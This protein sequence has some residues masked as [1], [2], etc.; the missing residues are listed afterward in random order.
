MKLKNSA[1]NLISKLFRGGDK[2]PNR[3]RLPGKPSKTR[4]ALDRAPK[5]TLPKGFKSKEPR[6]VG[7][8]PNPKLIKKI[9]RKLSGISTKKIVPLSLLLLILV[10]SGL[11]LKSLGVFTIDEVEITYDGSPD[12]KFTDVK[13]YEVRGRMYGLNYFSVNLDKI[14]SE[15][16]ATKP[17]IDYVIAEKIF[18]RKVEIKIFESDPRLTLNVNDSVC[19]VV[20][21]S[22]L[23][24]N[25]IKF[26]HKNAEDSDQA[27]DNDNNGTQTGH[28][29]EVEDYLRIDQEQEISVEESEST[30]DEQVSF[31]E[32][33]DDS[34]RIEL[35]QDDPIGQESELEQV[36]DENALLDE[37]SAMSAEAESLI[38]S[39]VAGFYP[40]EFSNF[41]SC[42]DVADFYGTEYV[43]LINSKL[44]YEIGQQS[45]NYFDTQI[46][47]ILETFEKYNITITDFSVAN[48]IC[49][50]EDDH[51]SIFLIALN[52]D[53]ELQLRRLEII[54][55]HFI[56]DS[57]RYKIVD[58]RY[59]RPVLSK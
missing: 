14:V 1:Q 29:Q 56:S 58:L 49:S 59:K 24:L 16:E 15:L 52:G 3:S 44:S 41:D 17:S 57:N 51:G 22:N 20:D 28:S 40:P 21:D 8:D 19:A 26:A 11:I 25:H 9:R 55:Q 30:E 36:G 39:E 37:D 32:L 34:T 46:N 10:F 42:K 48:E 38:I 43:R 33:P 12:A 4:Q 23:V 54:Q 47:K 53:V 31:L 13:E 45:N 35:E 5:I 7:D 2:I 6:F 18:P 27:A 50:I